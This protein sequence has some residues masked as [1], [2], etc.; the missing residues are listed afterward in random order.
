MSAKTERMEKIGE[1]KWEQRNRHKQAFEEVLAEA[2]SKSLQDEE[3]DLDAEIEDARYNAISNAIAR[4]TQQ[5]RRDTANASAA[6][7]ANEVRE[8]ENFR[9]WARNI[10][11]K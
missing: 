7:N 8:R 2:M 5:G 9:A 6:V 4:Q 10:F 3:N 1:A 11:A